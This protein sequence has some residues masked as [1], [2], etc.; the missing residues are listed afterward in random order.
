MNHSVHIIQLP[1]QPLSFNAMYIPQRMISAINPMKILLCDDGK[2]TAQF[3][4]VLTFNIL[5]FHNF[6][7]TSAETVVDTTHDPIL[8]RVRY[9]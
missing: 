2:K 5:E 1:A 9:N 3:Q 4:L 6:R 7:D 8:V